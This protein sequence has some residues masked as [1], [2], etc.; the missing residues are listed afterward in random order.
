[1][2]SRTVMERPIHQKKNPSFCWDEQLPIRGGGRH[3]TLI[4]YAYKHTFFSNPFLILKGIFGYLM[5]MRFL[6]GTR[7]KQLEGVH[8]RLFLPLSL[9]AMLT[10]LW[11]CSAP[12]VIFKTSSEFLARNM[13]KSWDLSYW[14][15]VN[16]F[17][18]SAASTDFFIALLVRD[19]SWC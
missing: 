14:V 12:L 15:R 18:S 7:Q 1:M 13:E 11:L 19:F 5:E 3:K 4:D 10:Q 6:G 8:M 17:V 16:E 2:K 9:H